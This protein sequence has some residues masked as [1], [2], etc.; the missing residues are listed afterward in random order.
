MSR[1]AI[2]HKSRV[3]EQTHAQSIDQAGAMPSFDSSPMFA[4]GY[5]IPPVNGLGDGQGGPR[6]FGYMPGINSIPQPRHTEAISFSDLRNLATLY[7]GV[8]ICERA[9]FRVLRRL[10]LQVTPRPGI[11]GCDPHG[12]RWM[13]EWFA[14]PEKRGRDLATW[15]VAALRDNLELDAIAI[16]HRH[17]REGGLHSLEVIDGATITPLVDVGGRRPLP[18]DPAFAQVLY[19]Q[20]GSLWTSAD[21]DYLVEHPR[22]NSMYGAPIVESIVL[23]INQALRKE[24]YDLARFTDGATPGGILET[25]D[26]RLMT[27]KADQLA[28]LERMWNAVLAGNDALR[29]RTRI[30]PPGWTFK[31]MQSEAIALD[32]DQWLLHLTVAAFGL[33]MDELGFTETS[34]RA[35]G[36]AQERVMY[37]NAVRPRADLFARYFTNII[38]RYQGTPLSATATS[39]SAA[40]Q[41]TRPAPVWDACYEVIWTGMD[42]SPDVAQMAG[43]AAE[44]VKAGIL[45]TDEA[46]RWLHL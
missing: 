30:V 13:E 11:A 9:I 26:A 34:N 16:F 43:A 27:M 46:R 32:F 5:P 33:T 21:L 40:G 38:R 37:R 35:V 31:S 20:V 24:H 2:H 39:F 29:V 8:Q 25:T 23:R 6:E 17:T 18:P 3:I 10:Q 7:E 41:P 4:P 42:E 19:G 12:G 22:T 36:D 28:A 15:L 1:R 44:L 45:T 14:D